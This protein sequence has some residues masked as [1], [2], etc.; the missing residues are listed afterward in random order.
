M[1]ILNTVHVD[2]R[3]TF[4]TQSKYFFAQLYNGS[5][6]E[7][8]WITIMTLLKSLYTYFCK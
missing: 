2:I 3:L 5:V 6:K 8:P 1:N 7:L 4:L